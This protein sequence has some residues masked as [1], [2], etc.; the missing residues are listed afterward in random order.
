MRI[1]AVNRQIAL[2]RRALRHKDVN[3]GGFNRSSEGGDLGREKPF[4]PPP[5][6]DR[7]NRGA[8][9]LH[10]PE[11]PLNEPLQSAEHEFVDDSAPSKMKSTE[12][13]TLSGQTAAVDKDMSND[14][15]KEVLENVESP[16]SV[17]DGAK[18]NEEGDL[19]VESEGTK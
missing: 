19:S 6:C 18:K 14:T 2:H 13:L 8:G 5:R 17:K 12:R 11:R 7:E 3:E 16:S 1:I 4:K 9:R 10:F 15:P